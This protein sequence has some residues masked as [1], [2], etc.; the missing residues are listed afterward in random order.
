ME[1]LGFNLLHWT[2]STLPWENISDPKVVEEKK[3][4]L[5]VS[6]ASSSKKLI[7]SAPPG[8]IM[9]SDRNEFNLCQK[10]FAT[11]IFCPQQNQE[12][13]FNSVKRPKL[14]LLKGWGVS[15]GIFP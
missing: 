2:T 12:N 7:P 3:K 11:P 13:Y 4:S 10:P 8:E 6:F 9:F 14:A 15:F 5:M 1:I